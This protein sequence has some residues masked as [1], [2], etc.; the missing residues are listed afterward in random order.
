IE[1]AERPG[2]MPL[3]GISG[4]QGSGKTTLARAAA[5]ALGCAHLSLDDVYLTRAERER[6]AHEVH[7]LFI[8]R[9]PPGTHDLDLLAATFA[10]L[11]AAGPDNTTALPAFD[12]L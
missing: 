9:G 4:A 3:I 6:M 12:K 7:P 8:T 2:H 1:A 5:G 11:G 10:A